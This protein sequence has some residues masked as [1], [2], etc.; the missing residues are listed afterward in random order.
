[1]I[2]AAT[3]PSALWYLTRGAGAVTLLLL[4]ASLVLGIMHVQRGR[5]GRAPRLLVESAHRT[6]SLLVLVVLTLHVV[7]A[8]LD[9]FAP[10]RLLDAFVP[11]ASA[12]RP[13]W[14][15]FG[16]VALDLL[17]A[18][19]VTSLVRAR[20]GYRAWRAVHWAAY[21]CWPV[22]V[23][24]GLG[25][26]S[27]ARTTWLLALTLGCVAAVVL[28]LGVRLAA[29]GPGRFRRRGGAAVAIAAGVVALAVWLPQGPL[30]DGWARRSGTPP[31]LLAAAAPT[32]ADRPARNAARPFS[33]AVSGT[34][35][36]GTAGD[37]TAVVDLALRGPRARER[38]RVRLA[39]RPVDDGGVALDRSAV[40]LRHDGTLW[41]GRISRL[42]GNV[43]DALVGAP[44]GRALRLRLNLDLSGPVV[45]GQ[46]EGR[47]LR[48]GATG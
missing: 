37:G 13:L 18:L 5:P 26:G 40:S 31:S 4:T 36:D 34:E 21:A 29:S 8:V 19:T 17:L 15:G 30:A 6:I 42:R 35:H 38:V 41:S 33:V 48:A 20:L 10:I 1:M 45:R 32:G 2:V 23:A 24:H 11:F 43:V 3:G 7:T 46:L 28:A 25:T 16:A 47:P 22:A 9:P 27:D 39:G 14:L 44:D 12:Y